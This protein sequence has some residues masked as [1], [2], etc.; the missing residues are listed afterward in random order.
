MKLIDRMGKGKEH[1]KAIGK[2]V[3]Y[4]KIM[5]KFIRRWEDNITMNLQEL[6][7]SDMV[8]G[9]STIFYRLLLN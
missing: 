2:I 9:P 7:S 3:F 8:R 4:S 6:V 1:F 5:C